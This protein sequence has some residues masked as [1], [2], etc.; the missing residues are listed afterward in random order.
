MYST[1]N[2]LLIR[3]ENGSIHIFDVSS[4]PWEEFF[5]KSFK[6]KEIFKFIRKNGL[7][8]VLDDYNTEMNCKY[9]EIDGYWRIF[10]LPSVTCH[11][12]T[13]KRVR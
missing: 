10:R 12:K 7:V 5:G 2:I 11:G 4:K 8:I 13:Y 6:K 3:V 1:G 9:N